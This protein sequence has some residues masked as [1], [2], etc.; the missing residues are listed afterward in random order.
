MSRLFAK[1]NMSKYKYFDNIRIG[2]YNDYRFD[3]IYENWEVFIAPNW[4]VL[5][6]NKEKELIEKLNKLASYER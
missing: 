6:Y 2:R 3:K 4:I 1:I 5:D